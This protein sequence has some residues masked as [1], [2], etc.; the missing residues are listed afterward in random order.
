[1]QQ[2]YDMI[3]KPKI[4]WIGEV[5]H[6]KGYGMFTRE[7]L[8]PI[9]D[10]VKLEPREDH[11]KPEEKIDDEFWIEQVVEG[12]IKEKA[13]INVNFCIPH[14][15][16]PDPERVNLGLSLWDT[17]CYPREWIMAMNQMDGILSISEDMRDALENGG[18]KVPVR[19]FNPHLNLERFTTEG[20]V[21]EVTG[22]E[23]LIKFFYE[24]DWNKMSGFEVLIPIFA[25]ATEQIKD[26]C[27][28]IKT[29]VA[30]DEPDKRR[31][32]ASS[33]NEIKKRL[34]GIKPPKIFLI[35]D[36]LTE[37]QTCDLIRGCDY[38]LNGMLAST[39]DAAAIRAMACGLPAIGHT[40]SNKVN[41][42]FEATGF[43]TPILQ[44]QAPFYG[45]YQNYSVPDSRELIEAIRYAYYIKK[46][47][48]E[49]Y[50]I[51]SEESSTNIKRMFSETDLIQVCED[52]KTYID[53]NK[54]KQGNSPMLAEQNLL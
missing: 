41:L 27:L 20:P 36:L 10:E 53:E 23:N 47:N 37:S 25:I 54:S 13:D 26:A 45:S 51:L 7:F 29:G 31:H 14:L 43:R 33:I 18:I 40:G 21:T 5:L 52:L 24:A 28:I 8:K 39:I 17:D 6:N 49:K 32:I 34:S 15:Y 38:Y 16:K 3:D 48:R 2:R 4:N 35:T 19:V 1:M 12:S 46:T 44:T 30:S 9:V 11:I 22:T 50:S 42:A